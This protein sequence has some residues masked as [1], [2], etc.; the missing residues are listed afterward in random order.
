MGKRNARQDDVEPSEKPDHRRYV[1]LGC[2][3]TRSASVTNNDH[4]VR[5]T[6]ALAL[7]VAI[8]VAA[9]SAPLLHA[10]SDE[11][12]TDHH[13]GRSIHSHWSA[14]PL[15]HHESDRSVITETDDDQE[16]ALNTFVAESACSLHVPA[17]VD[18]IVSVPVPVERPA[19]RA[20]ETVRGHDP[21][22]LKSRPSRAPPAFLS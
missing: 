13:R 19:H 9:I 7:S 5:K 6:V 10:H 15:V 16:I 18:A 2:L 22:L 4:T 11:H 8:Q 12:D 21:P 20:A 17:D 14:H 1:R 3:L